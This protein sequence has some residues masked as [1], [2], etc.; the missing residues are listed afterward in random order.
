[1]LV[2]EE[3]TPVPITGFTERCVQVFDVTWEDPEIDR[4]F[5]AGGHDQG[6]LICDAKDLSGTRTND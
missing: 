1:M 6:V 3:G 5:K 4:E 2:G